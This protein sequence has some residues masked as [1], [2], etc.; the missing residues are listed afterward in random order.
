MSRRFDTIMALVP[1]IDGG[2]FLALGRER[3]GR[4]INLATV[5]SSVATLRYIRR[6]EVKTKLVI[7]LIH[8][9]IRQDGIAT[10]L[11]AWPRRLVFLGTLS[12][13]LISSSSADP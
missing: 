13:S 7:S 10:L 9:K 6:T 12:P 3:V 8:D 1:A 4:C 5:V 11:A 2:R